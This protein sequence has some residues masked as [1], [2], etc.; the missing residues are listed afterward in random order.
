MMDRRDNS[1][2]TK[3]SREAKEKDEDSLK[4]TVADIAEHMEPQA[5]TRC[6]ATE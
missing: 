2:L 3:E 5:K 6:H 4:D 1:N